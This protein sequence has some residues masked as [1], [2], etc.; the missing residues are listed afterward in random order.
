MFCL[1]GE[2]VR[3]L[4]TI[5]KHAQW[6]KY[7]YNG[8]EFQP[9]FGLAW[10]DYGARMYD[11]QVGRWWSADALTEYNFNITPYHYVKNNPILLIDPFG[12]KSDSTQNMNIVNGVPV[13]QF[14]IDEVTKVWEKPGWLKKA[15]R[16]VSAW[17]SSGDQSGGNSVVH[18]NYA[19]PWTLPGGQGRD[20]T[21]ADEWGPGG[22]I[23]L[24]MAVRPGAGPLL[25]GR[26]LLG[27]ASSIKKV[28]DAL[29]N[30]KPTPD[31]KIIQQH[32][33]TV[34]QKTDGTGKPIK[35]RVKSLRFR[36]KYHSSKIDTI[37]F[38]FH[39]ENDT[40]IT[41]SERLGGGSFFH[42]LNNNQ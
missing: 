14:S 4:F 36:I 24:F 12:L 29:T 16:K 33:G 32:T 18:K 13:P 11:P 2:R 7:L 20:N 42:Y 8:K 37:L 27:I 1:P 25:F 30:I 40:T 6:E 10:Y 9:D 3:S 15:W 31:K 28:G 38:W 23:Y 41:I 5:K 17:W 34:K 19:E 22:S 39:G 21:V 26:N 35:Q